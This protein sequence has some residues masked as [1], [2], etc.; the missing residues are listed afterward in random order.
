MPTFVVYLFLHFPGAFFSTTTVL[1]SVEHLLFK[2]WNEF[3]TLQLLIEFSVFK[4]QF[5][6]W[7]TQRC[8]YKAKIKADYSKVKRI[9]TMVTRMERLSEP[10]TFQRDYHPSETSIM[11]HSRSLRGRLRRRSTIECL[12]ENMLTS[13]HGKRLSLDDNVQEKDRKKKYII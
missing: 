10:V 5:R 1:F 9:Y 11:V 3:H 7:R 4:T 13:T 2:S 6:N 8:F 12:N